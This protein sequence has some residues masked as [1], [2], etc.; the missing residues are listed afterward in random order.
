LLLNE[1]LTFVKNVKNINKETIEMLLS[2]DEINKSLTN[3]G[4]GYND[5]EITKSYQFDTYIDGIE[6]I[7][8]VARL[9]EA[10]NHHPEIYIRWCKVDVT[11]SSHDMDGVTTKCVNL[12]MD[13][14]LI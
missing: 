9:A 12:A 4:W 11:I 10:H 1:E 5:N 7:N 2:P 14:D 3:K 6:F 8:K 13:I